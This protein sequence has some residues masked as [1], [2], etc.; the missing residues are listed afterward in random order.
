MRLA[1]LL[2]DYATVAEGKLFI[3]GGGWSNTGP[4]PVSGWMVSTLG[5]P[6]DRTNTQLRVTFRLVN[7]DGQPFTFLKDDQSVPVIVEADLEVGRPPG[8]RKGGEFLVPFV[9]P[10]GP[11]DLTPG[12]RFE[13]TVSVGDE[14]HDDWR[15][16][17]DVRPLPP[18]FVLPGAG[19]TGF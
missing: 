10:F 18:G 14:K 19:I 16:P 4:G 2:A 11:L 17:F 5:V 12:Q 6:Y 3:S 8:M 9:F 1:L 15:L 13:W 7:Q